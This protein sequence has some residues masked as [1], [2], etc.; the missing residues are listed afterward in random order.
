MALLEIL[1]FPDPVLRERSE[2]VTVFDA[3]LKKLAEDMSDTMYAAPGVGLAAPQIGK[4]IRMV[5]V[6]PNAGTEE[7]KG[8]EVYINPVILEGQGSVISEEGCL[9]LPDFYEE[10]KRFEVVKVQA[11]DL[12]GQTFERTLE[13][14]HAVILQHELD[15]LNGVLAVDKVSRLKRAIYSKRRKRDL[16]NAQYRI[17]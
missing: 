10:V 13:G 3:A 9:S 14:F 11:K 2:P 12:D 8:P 5:L 1:T 4:L 7:S 15:H 17:D 16:R 6:D